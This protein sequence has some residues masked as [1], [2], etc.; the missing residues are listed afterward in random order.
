MSVS[1][2]FLVGWMAVM[3]F[4]VACGDETPPPMTGRVQLTLTVH[5]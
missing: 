2:W 1:S 5:K 3:A 4:A